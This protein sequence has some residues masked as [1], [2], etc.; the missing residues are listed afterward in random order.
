MEDVVDGDAGV[1]GV[2]EF[3]EFEAGETTL[4]LME[5]DAG[6]VEGAAEF[7]VDVFLG[8]ADDALGVGVAATFALE[9]VDAVDESVEIEIVFFGAEEVVEADATL[10]FVDAA[11][12]EEVEVDAVVFVGVAAETVVLTDAA[13]EVFFLVGADGAGPFAVDGAVDAEVETVP[14]A[15]ATAAGFAEAGAV[16]TAA[17]AAARGDAVAVETG[18]VKATAASRSFD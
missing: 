2:D 4:A 17:A 5:V 16:A 15:A 7:D 8:A 12:D 1:F 9:E 18:G 6:V 13:A 3:D 11:V 10:A 14:A